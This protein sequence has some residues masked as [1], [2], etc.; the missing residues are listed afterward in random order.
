[1]NV[2]N[3][4]AGLSAEE[5]N[6]VHKKANA[7]MNAVLEEFQKVRAPL[8]NLQ[9]EI[10]D[11][12]NRQLDENLQMLKVLY[13]ALKKRDLDAMAEDD[14]LTMKEK[15]DEKAERVEEES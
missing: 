7:E 15:E 9:Q 5:F 2:I 10:L 13:Q 1:L 14:L 12:Y 8:L 6:E 3:E 11:T 4:L